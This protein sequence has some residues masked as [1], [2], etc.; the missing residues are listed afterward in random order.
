MNVMPRILVLTLSFGSGHVRACQA[1]A[2]ELNRIAP[3]AE[4]KTVDALSDCRLWF[5]M[6]YVWPYWL[7]LRY[8]PGL[9]KRLNNAR[10]ENRHERTAPNWVFRFGCPRIFH[11]IERFRPD[12]IVA[13]EV[14]ACEIA[15][16]ARQE[17]LTLAS[18]VCVITDFESEPI[19]I[20]PAVSRYM[21]PDESVRAELIDWGAPSELIEICGI[22]VDSEFEVPCTYPEVD[23]NKYPLVL[24]MGGGMGPT[25]MAE[26]ARELGNSQAAM[27]IVAI[28]GHD[29]RAWR[30]LNRLTVKPPSSLQVVGWTDKIAS[31]MQRARILVTKPG[32]LT[33]SEA[34]LCGLPMVLF[35]PIPGAEYLNAKRMVDAGA[36][37]MTCGAPETAAEVLSLLH[38]EMRWRTMSINVSRISRPDARRQIAKR[39]LEV[40]T[41]RQM[42]QVA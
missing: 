22:P 1:I 20:K 4:I 8:A 18:I 35:D 41:L 11:L 21:V 26:V 37:L 28:A 13:G 29:K 3:R 34:Q 23:Q 12:V 27:R 10:L 36:A 42:Q 30:K 14:G 16:I 39:V 31:L 15:S 6:I 5:R 9:W 24:L 25:R 40:A 32:G 38:D 19:W 33:I 2:K 17:D 7:M